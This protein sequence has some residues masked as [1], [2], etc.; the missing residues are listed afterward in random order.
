MYVGGVSVE[1]KNWLDGYRGKILELAQRVLAC[2]SPSGYTGNV[3]KLTASLAEEMGYPTRISRRGALCINVEGRDNSKT[4]A[5]FAHMDT[6]GLSLRHITDRGELMF[7]AIGSILLPTLDGEYCRIYTR[8][9]KMYTGTVLSLS[10]AKHVFSD[11]ATRVRD[12]R[13]MYIRLD[14]PVEC[15]SDVE[16][17]GI[18]CGDIICIDPK[19]QVTDSGYLKSRF[20]DDKGS[21]A[22]L[23]TLLLAMKEKGL[24]PR[25]RTNI[26]FTVYEEVDSGCMWFPEELE[27]F[28]VVDMGCVGPELNCSEHQVSICAKDAAGPYDYDMTTRLIHLAEEHGI[29]Y[30]VDDYPYYTSDG[31]VAWQAGC[32]A[33]GALIGPGVHASHGMERT[34]ADGLLNTMKLV[35]CYL[36]CR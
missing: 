14:E 5:C 33:P 18:R 1:E 3:L 12:D 25:Y 15:K 29:D 32:D 16:A 34:H 2:D 11:A 35:A 20:I 6:L 21:V 9:G 30:A 19:T 13:N 23:L 27:E 4:V 17:L 24:K 10:P 26:I 22:V 8:E 7:T 31:L 28:L 36:D